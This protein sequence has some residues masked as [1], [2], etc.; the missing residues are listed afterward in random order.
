MPLPLA[1]IPLIAQG[2]GGLAQTLF[3]GKNKRQRELENLTNQTPTYSGGGGS[4]DFYQKALGRYNV[5]PYS[6]PLYASQ[7]QNAQRSTNM[8]LNALNDRRSALGG[9]GRLAAIQD[10]ASLRAGIAAENEQSRRFGQL[11]S[12]AG[13]AGQEEK[14]RYNTNQLN[15]YLRK[16]QLANQKAAGAGAVQSAGLQNMFGSLSNASYLLGGKNKI[17]ITQ[18]RTPTIDDYNSAEYYQYPENNNQQTTA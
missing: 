13:M 14:Y 10:D 5:N 7:M 9:V 8:G 6:S 12:A 18:K 16:L 11:G 15:P 1:A 2:I 17:P 4:T 3:S